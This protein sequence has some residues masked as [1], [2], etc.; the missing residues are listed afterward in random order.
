MKKL[1]VI[2]A[3]TLLTLSLL[4]IKPKNN[5][6]SLMPGDISFI[7]MQSHNNDGFVIITSVSLPPNTKIHFTD[8]EWNGNH[9]GF[10]ESDIIWK[11]GNDT[12]QANTIIKFMNLNSNP[13]VST[14]N[15]YG[16]MKISEK[17]DAIF[18]YT[19]NARM[20]IKIIA[21]CANNDLSFGTL[22]NTNLTK[23]STAILFQ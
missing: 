4:I 23:G 20:P 19:G 17:Q 1:K 3:L 9:F 10:D 18:A 14:G 16:S 8:S 6:K 22:I 2:L 11:T 12:I 13:T 21:A 15:I 5:Q 7:S